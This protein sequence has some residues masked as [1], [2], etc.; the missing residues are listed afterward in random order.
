[1]LIMRVPVRRLA[2]VLIFAA[3]ACGGEPEQQLLAVDAEV[4]ED[5]AVFED[6]SVLED[7]AIHDDAE[8]ADTGPTGCQA[9]ADCVL[10]TE[11][12]GCAIGACDLASGECTFAAI[13][14]DGDGVATSSCAVVGTGTVALGKDC[15]DDDAN[16]GPGMFE[17]CN[18]FDDDCNGLIDDGIAPIAVPCVR[19]LGASSINMCRTEGFSV[20]IAGDPFAG[21][22]AVPPDP[23]PDSLHCD[24]FSWDCNDTPNEGCLCITGTTQP[25]ALANGCP[26]S[27]TCGG[28]MWGECVCG[29]PGWECTPGE[30]RACANDTCPSD[31]VCGVDGRWQPCGRDPSCHPVFGCEQVLSND[32]SAP[33]TISELSCFFSGCNGAAGGGR[34]NPAPQYYSGTLPPAG[35]GGTVGGTVRAEYAGGGCFN[36]PNEVALNINCYAAL[37]GCAE[38][39]E[40]WGLAFVGGVYF[41]QAEATNIGGSPST[42]KLLP[43]T[44]T[45]GRTLCC[46]TYRGFSDWTLEC[47]G[48]CQRRV[49][50]DWTAT[51]PTACY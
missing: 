13:D 12:P 29:D 17:Q 18:N 42:T 38:P 2:F 3:S 8:P 49:V 36:N 40:G 9:S 50:F 48:C 51:A 24:N 1:M 32:A 27:Q 19:P 25:C 21:C 15:G 5:A 10:E 16:V 34:L 46:D 22:T 11:P 20:C 44:G 14:A 39:P 4:F 26:G 37:P 43:S 33:Y 47:Q 23:Q 6:A 35:I 28:N 41:T 31:Q 45:D 7:A 30:L